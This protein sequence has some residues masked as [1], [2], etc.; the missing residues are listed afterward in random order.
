M[1]CTAFLCQIFVEQ[2]EGLH[3][4]GQFEAAA[5]LWREAAEL[6]AQHKLLG[7]ALLV[8][9]AGALGQAELWQQSIDVASR[10]FA[11]DQSLRVS[12]VTNAVTVSVDILETLQ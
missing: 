8:R 3:A 2:G 11:V 5:N 7:G 6:D 4:Q 9:A 12:A 10:A 1:Y